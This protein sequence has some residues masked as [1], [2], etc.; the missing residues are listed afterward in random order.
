ASGFAVLALALFAGRPEAADDPKAEPKAE[1]KRK[2]WTRSKITGSPEPPP[3]FKSVRVFPEWVKFHHGLLI[4]HC[5]GSDR[6]FVGEQEGVLYSVANRPDAKK[7]LFCDLKKEIKT[8]DKLPGAKDVGEL[9][10]L[11]F[12]PKFAENRYCYVCYTLNAKEAPKDG[13]FP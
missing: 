4:A 3:K 9:Y 8:I 10:G 6:F 13:R 11:V 5:P 1:A 7:E 2:P 12:H